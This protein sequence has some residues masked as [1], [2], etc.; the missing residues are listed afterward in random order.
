VFE[1]ATASTYEEFYKI[2]FF[3]TTRR[4]KVVSV[5]GIAVVLVFGLISKQ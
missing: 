2:F 3:T 4:L 1:T 5:K